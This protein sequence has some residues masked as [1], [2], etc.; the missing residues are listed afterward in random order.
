MQFR[1]GLQQIVAHHAGLDA[2]L[3]RI[4]LG[5]LAQCE[6][7]AVSLGQP[8][9]VVVSVLLDTEQFGLFQRIE[10]S[11]GRLA[12][13]VAEIVVQKR[14]RQLFFAAGQMDVGAA[15]TR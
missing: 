4:D 7:D 12:A 9:H 3:R 10:V 11:Q 5:D 6:F 15:L 14:L 13:Q 8:P 2:A 1:L